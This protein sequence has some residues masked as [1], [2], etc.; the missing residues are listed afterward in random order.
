M[1]YDPFCTNTGTGNSKMHDIK[2]ILFFIETVY[3]LL[4]VK[5]LFDKVP[6]A[7]ISSYFF[8]YKDSH[9]S[10]TQQYTIDS[11]IYFYQDL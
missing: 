3:I 4:H 6:I 10:L 1:F 8:V 7:W 2:T 5:A 11:K 9:L